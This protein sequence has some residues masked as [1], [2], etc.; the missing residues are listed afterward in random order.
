MAITVTSPQAK[1]GFIRNATSADASG[2]EEILAGVTG[3]KIKISQLTI[4]S[5]SALTV[6]IGEGVAASSPPVT[7][8]LIG[9]VALAANTSLQ[10]NFNP[11]LRLTE[12]TAL[13]V[14]ASGAGNICVFCQGFVQ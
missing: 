11:Y 4:N 2:T 14:T 8:D 1:Q 13:T 10:L 9:P 12:A 7:T 5:D 3:K 6:T